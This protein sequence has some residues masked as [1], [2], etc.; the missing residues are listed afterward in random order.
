MATDI[1]RNPFCQIRVYFTK[2]L[3]KRTQKGKPT[4]MQGAHSQFQPSAGIVW[5]LFI[6]LHQVPAAW[7]RGH[8]SS[9]INCLH[10][11]V[12]V[13]ERHPGKQSGPLSFPME[14]LL[15]WMATCGT[16]TH[17]MFFNINFFLFLLSISF[18]FVNLS[19]RHIYEKF[20]SVHLSSPQFT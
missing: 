8:Q 19:R 2:L 4:L 7:S 12:I 16:Q 5:A 18:Y 3:G 13:E 15:Y 14:Y 11:P 17:L 9:W 10:Y 20:T 6:L 1:W